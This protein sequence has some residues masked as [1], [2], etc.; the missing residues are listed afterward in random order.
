MSISEI[1]ILPP[2]AIARL[3]SSPEPLDNYDLYID[4]EDPLGFRRIVPAE[5][6]RVDRAT[7]EVTG[8]DVPGEVRFKDGDG[9]I[10]PVA[11]FLEVWAVTG[12]GCLE[13]LTLDLLS[14]EGAAASDVSWSVHVGNVKA[15]RRTGDPHD[16]IEAVAG[17]FSDHGAH[18]LLGKCENFKPGRVLTL[19][20]VQYLKP[21]AR[22]P[23]VRLRFT[24]AVGAV[25]GPEVDDNVPA[26]HDVYDGVKG[27]WKGYKEDTVNLEPTYTIPGAIYAGFE[28]PENSDIWVS[29]GYLDDECDGVVEVSL[30]LGART[31][32]AFARIGAGPPAFAP[33]SFP[34]RT[35][36]DELEQA[37][38]GPVV[39][40]ADL[41]SGEAEEIVRRAFETVRLMQTAVMNGNVYEGQIDV[42]S[43]MVRQDTGDTGRLFEPIMAPSLVDT[44][45]VQNLHQNVFTA[46]RSGMAPWFT[47]VLRRYDEIGDLSSVGRRKMPALMR[48]ADG[49]YMTLTRRQVDTVQKTATRR[50]FTTGQTDDESEHGDE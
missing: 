20:S 41:P 11:P 40:A 37:L 49:R 22:F 18:E 12:D 47:D 42:A 21:T 17:P 6:L 19:G 31:L 46:L 16:R 1:R 28:D 27:T 7:G 4:P 45:A 8:V 38:L 36:A 23:E 25:Y 50:L 5:T 15:C 9:R 48:G 35:V 13:P 14:G 39:A 34:P 2:L 29:R 32:S 10:H 44:L 30:T 3:G 24:P 26:G 43:T 33:D